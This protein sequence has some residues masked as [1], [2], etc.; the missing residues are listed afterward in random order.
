[1]SASNRS[2]PNK[3]VQ[4]WTSESHPSIPE[5][6]ILLLKETGKLQCCKFFGMWPPPLVGTISVTD[7]QFYQFHLFFIALQCIVCRLLYLLP[8]YGFPC[9]LSMLISFQF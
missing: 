2:F 3:R 1:M 8:L 7:R 5:L 9:S 4:F 6:T